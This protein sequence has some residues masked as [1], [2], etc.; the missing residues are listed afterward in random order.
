[1]TTTL[2]PSTRVSMVMVAASRPVSAWAAL[3]KRFMN[4]WLI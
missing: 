4:T 1:L 3:V 2:S